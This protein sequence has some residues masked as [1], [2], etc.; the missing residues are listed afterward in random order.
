M[1][2]YS[3][4]DK[5]F[6]KDCYYWLFG[7]WICVSHHL[8]GQYSNASEGEVIILNFNAEHL[9]IIWKELA[10]ISAYLNLRNLSDSSWL[11]SVSLE[12]EN[13]VFTQLWQVINF[14]L[15]SVNTGLRLFR[16][17]KGYVILER[18]S[19]YN[20]SLARGKKQRNACEI[21]HTRD[22]TSGQLGANL[23]ISQLLN[24]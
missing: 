22:K 17:E 9:L 8:V 14:T 16:W 20:S 1:R 13:R 24:G 19:I 3:A 15:D 18:K 11:P 6:R 23:R 2:W 21:E 4:T 10:D 7:P 12:R 5:V